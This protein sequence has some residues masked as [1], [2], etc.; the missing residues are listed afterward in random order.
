[1]VCDIWSYGI[2]VY[3]IFNNGKKHFFEK[4][5][6][7]INDYIRRLIEWK[8]GNDEIWETD[9]GKLDY[10]QINYLNNFLQFIPNKRKFIK[11]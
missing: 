6:K 1:M 2:L 10:K 3:Y 5:P 8:N 4:T 9:N 7:C 11:Y